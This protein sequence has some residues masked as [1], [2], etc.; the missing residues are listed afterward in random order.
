MEGLGGKGRKREIGAAYEGSTKDHRP[1][2]GFGSIH[3]SLHEKVR[4]LPSCARQG[5]ILRPWLPIVRASYGFATSEKVAT[6]AGT[7]IA[8]QR[9]HARHALAHCFIARE[10]RDPARLGGWWSQTRPQECETQSKGD[11][12]ASL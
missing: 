10:P 11:Q 2:F 4:G 6:P 9:E 7:R 5:R 8:P 1:E 12:I 3:R